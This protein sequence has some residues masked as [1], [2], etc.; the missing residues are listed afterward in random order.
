LTC[1]LSRIQREANELQIDIDR[2]WLWCPAGP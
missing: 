2:R 1:F